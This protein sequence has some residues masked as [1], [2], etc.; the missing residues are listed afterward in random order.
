MYLLLFYE[1]K[2]HNSHFSITNELLHI[3]EVHKLVYDVDL[4]HFLRVCQEIYTEIRFLGTD[5]V[6]TR[7]KLVIILPRPL[8]WFRNGSI[9]LTDTLSNF[10]WSQT[11]KHSSQNVILI[12]NCIIPWDKNEILKFFC[13]SLTLCLLKDDHFR[14]NLY[15]HVKRR[16]PP[17]TT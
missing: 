5:M 12:W 2:D 7:T 9:H 13:F 3:Q 8:S 10:S 15:L 6:V 14:C 16:R 17:N 4:F 11:S 1:I